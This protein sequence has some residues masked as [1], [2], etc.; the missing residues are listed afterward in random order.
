MQAQDNPFPTFNVAI[1]APV[2]IQPS[3]SWIQSLQAIT[4]GKNNT[5]VIIVDDSDGKVKLPDSFDVY[6]YSRQSE[7]MGEDFYAAFE[8]FHKSAACKS[9]GIWLA[10]RDK[11]DIIIVLDSDCIVSPDFIGR[12]IEGLMMKVPGWTNPIKNTG[13]F[14][15][16]FALSQRT[17]PVA[18]SMGLWNH[19]LDL[20]GYDRALAAKDG[21]FPPTE[22][23]H[24]IFH[25][26]ADGFVPLS[27]MNVAFWARCAPAMLFLPNFEYSQEIEDGKAREY[28]FRR[29]DDIWGGYV[30]QSLMAKANERLVFGDPVVYHDT[31]VVPEEDAAEETDAI[32]FEEQ[33]Y[34][35]VDTLM[36]E[37]TPGEYDEMFEQFATIAMAKWLDSEW[38]PLAAAMLFWSN[39][40]T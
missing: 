36:G 28:R 38:E 35:Q 3:D 20:Y 10:W 16:G 19:E 24:Q 12:H 14:P 21:I 6:G 18:V 26:V 29:H 13:W 31:V 8:K 25:E 30:F 4:K 7:E 1:V 32:A 34:N 23:M 17:L 15:R 22:P 33:F 9:F 40:F 39:L 11:A 37:V 27:G 5:R 2:H